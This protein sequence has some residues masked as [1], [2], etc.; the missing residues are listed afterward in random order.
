MNEIIESISNREWA[1]LLWFTVLIVAIN[2]KKSIRDSFAGVLRAFFQPLIVVPLLLAAI[3]ATG[4]IYLLRHVGWWSLANLKS[5]VLWLITFAFVTMFEVASIKDKR[6][7]LGK[8]TRNIITVTSIFLFITELHS[9]SLPVE[10]IALP[11]VTFIVLTAEV[12]KLKPEHAPVSKIL[13]TVVVLIGLSYLGFSVWMT[14]K[15]FD[16][17]VTW[18]NALELLIPIIISVGFFPFLYAWRI[19]AAYNA[20]F[21]A[22]SIF[23][24][25]EKF[26]PY[27]RWLAITRIRGDVEL[28]ERWRKSIQ[29]SRPATKAELRHSLVALRALVER[30][31]SPP[32]IQPKDGWSPYHAMQFM[33][34][35]RIE[36]GHYHHSFD[37]EWSA[38]SPMR[39][40]GDGVMWKNNIAY[41]IE[42]NEQAATTLKLKLNINDPPCA[43]EAEDMFIIY[44]AHLLEQAVSLDAVERMK[45]D[46]AKLAPFAANIPYGSVCVIRDDFFGG[47][48]GG[49]SRKFEITRGVN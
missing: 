18:A 11:F 40:I 43:R 3:Y 29:A 48:K 33:T 16:H 49:Y 15:E 26:V 1:A 24:L 31:T 14:F 45:L 7:G 23:G 28:L 41:Y 17:T 21:V 5:T 42:G 37:D 39:E 13:G 34:D 12:A 25:D 30:E 22:I 38:S 10:I 20:A 4:E 44:C 46:I 2:V 47:I 36:T 27:A 19:Y 8:I 35:Y 32:V 9:F 6:V